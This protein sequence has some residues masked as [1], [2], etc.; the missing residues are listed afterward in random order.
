MGKSSYRAKTSYFLVTTNGNLRKISP[1]VV[2]LVSAL[3]L[4]AI[5]YLGGKCVVYNKQLLAE[6]EQI[7][8]ELAQMDFRHNQIADNLAVC[9]DNK[10]KIDGLLYFNAE[11]ENSTDEK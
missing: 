1:T 8:I 6:R 11:V 2:G 5:V 3:L 9:E 7:Q 10:R 4:S